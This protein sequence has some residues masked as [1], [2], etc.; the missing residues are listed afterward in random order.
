MKYIFSFLRFLT[1]INKVKPI[2]RY[3]SAESFFFHLSKMIYINVGLFCFQTSV[4]TGELIHE[5]IVQEYL[6]FFQSAI[7][8]KILKDE[9]TTRGFLIVGFISRYTD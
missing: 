9:T 2:N 3:D 6:I 1:W 4:V 5:V 7:I 8:D